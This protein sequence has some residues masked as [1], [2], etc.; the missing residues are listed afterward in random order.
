MEKLSL[1]DLPQRSPDE[2]APIKCWVV[3][4]AFSSSCP[5]IYVEYYYKKTSK[6]VFT[7]GELN[8]PAKLARRKDIDSS[9]G[10]Y[11]FDVDEALR[12]VRERVNHHINESLRI[13]EVAR[14]RLDEITEAEQTLQ[15][16]RE[17]KNEH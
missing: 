7:V 4:K 3:T 13:L 11:F 5:T 10:T 2:P 9:H 1:L 12:V 16:K 8:T 14:R 15:R 17:A 6:S